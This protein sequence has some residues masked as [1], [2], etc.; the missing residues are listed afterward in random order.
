MN[1]RENE[2]CR[3]L[4]KQGQTHLIVGYDEID[5]HEQQRFS[6]RSKG[7]TGSMLNACSGCLRTGTVGLL[8]LK[9]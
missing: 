9:T 1:E 3:L 5:E 2:V 4:A 8:F 7:L 6:T